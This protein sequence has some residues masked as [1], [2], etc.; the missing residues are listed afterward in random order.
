PAIA[1]Q[2]KYGI[3]MGWLAAAVMLVFALLH[4][5]R[6]DTFIPELGKALPGGDSFATFVCIAIVLMEVFALPF[7]LRMRLSVLAS[8]ISGLF[9][10]VVP[11]IWLLI[12]IWNYTS[13]VS[14]GQFGE[15]VVAEVNVWLLAG[16]LLW[17]C[18]AYITLWALGFD[19]AY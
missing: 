3:Y 13:T 19:K 2:Y 4:L 8:F 17:L 5:F 14:T 15:F 16:N 7:L 11:L 12:T 6:I 9:G 10:V 18:Y 1:L